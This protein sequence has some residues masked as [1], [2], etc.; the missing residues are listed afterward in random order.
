[1]R[2]L[3]NRQPSRGTGLL[4][5]ALPFVLLLLV[6]LAA[7]HERLAANPEDR[8]LPSLATLGQTAARLALEE[9]A[10]TGRVLLWQDTAA[11]LA[12]LGAGVGISALIA[13]LLG[14]ANGLIP[15]V[16]AGLSAFVAGLSLIP[17][18]AILPVLFIAFG[19]G[20]TAKVVLIVFGIAPFLVRDLQQ[21]VREIPREQIVK[22]ET[23]G[24]ST[25][26]V[27]LRV[28]LPQAL[29]RL[30]DGMRLSLGAAWLFLIAAEA[31]AAEQGLGYRIFLVRRYLAM[32]VIL[33]YVAWITLLAYAMDLGLRGLSRRLFPWFHGA[34]ARRAEAA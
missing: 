34:G 10:R 3:I 7:S 31:I 6:Y 25:W 20:E 13:L 33:P 12:R 2:R 24:A 5:A 26:L 1:V 28:A 21:R 18:M 8:L 27:A 17:P 14:I 23:L 29:P 16:R 32:D 11:S 9:D 30:M 15:Y 4:L 22:A 19:L